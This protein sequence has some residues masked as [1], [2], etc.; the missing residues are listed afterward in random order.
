MGLPTEVNNI[1]FQRLLGGTQR[2]RSSGIGPDPHHA[3]TGTAG[4]VQ[5]VPTEGGDESKNISQPSTD[6]AG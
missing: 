5:A 1:M 3:F 4:T 6:H 2:I